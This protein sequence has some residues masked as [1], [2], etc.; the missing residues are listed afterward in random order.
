L[1]IGCEPVSLET[2]GSPS[3]STRREIDPSKVVWTTFRPFNVISSHP[4]TDLKD[5]L[6]APFFKPREVTNV[7]LQAITRLGMLAEFFLRAG[8]FRVDLST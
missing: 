7:R 2:L 5:V 4:D 8:T 1:H 3:H 6:T